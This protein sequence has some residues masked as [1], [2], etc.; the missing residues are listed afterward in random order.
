MAADGSVAT[1]TNTIFSGA[2]GAPALLGHAPRYLAKQPSVGIDV[3]LSGH[4]AVECSF[5]FQA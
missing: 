4:N 5:S 3:D 1:L 2:P